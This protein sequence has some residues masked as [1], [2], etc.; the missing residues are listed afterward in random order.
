MGDP[1]DPRDP[2]SPTTPGRRRFLRVAGGGLALVVHGCADDTDGSGTDG[3]TGDTGDD[4]STES[5]T[6]SAGDGGSGTADGTGQ[7]T[8]TGDDTTGDDVPEECRGEPIAFDPDGIPMDET[9]FPLAVMAGAMK[10]TSV[11]LSTLIDDARPKRL[12][13]WRD[14][15]QDGMVHL[16]DDLD[17]TPDA[18]GYGKTRIENLCPGTWY[19]YGYF[20]DDGTGTLTARSLVGEFRTALEEN[21]LEPLTVALTSCNGYPN[22]PWPALLTTAE[23]YYDLFIHLGDM[24]YNDGSMSL[25]DF[26][27]SWR[28][29]LAVSDGGTQMGMARAYAR[30]GL[31][32]TWD[33]HE[34][35]DNFDPETV[36]PA[37]L[38][39]AIDAYWELIPLEGEDEGHRLWRSYRWGKTAEFIILD[40]RGERL[41]STRETPQAQY[42]SPEQMAWL[43]TRL[44]QSPCQ[45]KVVVNSVPITNMP[46][47]WDVAAE[48]RWEGYPAQRDALLDFI[49]SE[50]IDNVWFVAGDFHVCFVG[51][52][53]PGDQGVVGR[54]WEIAC[55]GG[56]TNPLGTSLPG[57]QFPYRTSSPRA[58]LL[59]F[60]PAANAV[61]VRFIDPETGDDAYNESLTP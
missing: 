16:I 8:T 10:P 4:G 61:N 7:G 13:I 20:A 39:N 15:P 30:A 18:D 26:R 34:V 25:E 55:T 32:A 51:R 60:D 43:Q 46:G 59:T 42:I 3:T 12:R 58:T 45:F 54:T 41:P 47:I 36:D 48:D 2:D 5:G 21:T 6:T 1:R 29:H 27:Q 22:R 19:R 23:E 31:Y 44:A 17:V 11:L 50:A 28:R 24:A 57:D 38:R 33:D 56:N 37:L 35:G 49:E 52:V 40:C 9:T 53:E 14:H